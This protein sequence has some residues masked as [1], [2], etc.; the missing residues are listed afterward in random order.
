M[1][2][3]TGKGGVKKG[4]PSRNPLGMSKEAR[5]ERDLANSLLLTPANDEVW[6]RA[7][8]T[9][10]TAGVAPVLL[11]YTYRRLGKPPE[12]LNVSDSRFDEL[13]MLLKGFT[14]D[15]RLAFLDITKET[16]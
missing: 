15:Q 12:S 13:L 16:E 5:A 8:M 10:V 9:A 11:D 4:D 1:S 7:Y 14:P 2:N 3:P 6:L